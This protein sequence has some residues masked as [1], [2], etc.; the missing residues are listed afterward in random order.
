MNY[1]LRLWLPFVPEGI[2]DEEMFYKVSYYMNG[3]SFNCLSEY[4]EMPLDKWLM[5]AQIHCQAVEDQK[6]AAKK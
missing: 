4:E 1:Y 2:P 5:L 3:C 6:Q